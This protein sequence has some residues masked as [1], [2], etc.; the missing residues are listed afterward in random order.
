M[1]R[2]ILIDI[3]GTQSVETS[4]NDQHEH[5]TESVTEATS[6]GTLK[7]SSFGGIGHILGFSNTTP[8]NFRYDANNETMMSGGTFG[9][10]Y[11]IHMHG[12]FTNDTSNA[13]VFALIAGTIDADTVALGE[14]FFANGV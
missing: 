1:N 6:A 5:I 4:W 8:L 11:A 3:E 9:N 12:N 2:S 7:D 13:N 10:V 14:T